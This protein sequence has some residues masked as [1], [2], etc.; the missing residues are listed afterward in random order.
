MA[1]KENNSDIANINK[2]FNKYFLYAI[3]VPLTVLADFKQ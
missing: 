1:W 3:Y 2:L